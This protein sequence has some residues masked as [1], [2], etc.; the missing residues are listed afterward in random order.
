MKTILFRVLCC[1]ALVMGAATPLLAQ[2]VSPVPF[3]RFR[4]SNNDLGF[5]YTTNFQD[6]VNRNYAPHGANGNSNGVIGFIVVPPTTSSVP[7]DGQGLQTLFRWHVNQ[8]GRHYWY[9]TPFPST[10]GSDYTF[11]GNLGYTFN[12]NDPRPGLVVTAFYSQRYGYFFALDGERLPDASFDFFPG[13]GPSN[14]PFVYTNPANG[15]NYCS[16]YN[17]HGAICK[18]LTGPSGSFEFTTPPPPPPPPPSS[19]SASPAIKSKCA[20]LGGSWSDEMCTCEY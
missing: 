10:H 9:I 20:Q 7:V 15:L 16:T 13:T 4:V 8:D 2:F 19:C 11:E 1:L 5:F 14:C 3:Y 12:L 17:N 18:L 6:G